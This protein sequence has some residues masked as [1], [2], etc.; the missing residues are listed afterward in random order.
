MG[1]PASA[2]QSGLP[3][4]HLVVRTMLGDELVMQSVQFLG[5]V[6]SVLITGS[7]HNTST[8]YTVMHAL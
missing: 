6:W 1:I 3:V 4:V 5:S 7:S 2:C 8:W